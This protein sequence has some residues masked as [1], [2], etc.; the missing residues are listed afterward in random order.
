ML[1]EPRELPVDLTTNAYQDQFPPA[2]KLR[3]LPYDWS[4]RHVFDSGCNIGRLGPF[5]LSQGAAS[6]RGID[7]NAAYIAEARRR[8][9][10]LRYDVGALPDADMATDVL[11]VLGVFHH[12]NDA[13]VDATFAKTAARTVIFENPFGDKPLGN[14]KI[15]PLAWYLAHA[16]RAGFAH[17]SIYQYGFPYSVD[18]RIVVVSK[19]AWDV[20]PRVDL[21]NHPEYWRALGVLPAA[22]ELLV[23][24]DDPSAYIAWWDSKQVPPRT[25]GITGD[26]HI[27]YLR[28]LVASLR[29]GY[30]AGAY[31]E[32]K[33]Q[34]DFARDGHGPI[35][36]VRSGTG[37]APRDGQHRACILKALGNPVMACL[38]KVP[39]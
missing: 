35:T 39:K 10:D 6:Y 7:V 11:T 18:R 34:L 31:R 38:W 16:A 15:R 33:R 28:S 2:R 20:A 19:D 1:T 3:H 36:V 9:P 14:Y 5:V 21:V 25:D 22:I 30:R 4:G 17:H 13:A 23:K 29:D 24:H 32:G 27:P 8:S 37:V 26:H 12:M